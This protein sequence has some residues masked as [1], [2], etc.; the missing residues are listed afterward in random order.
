MS[1]GTQGIT[2]VASELMVFQTLGLTALFGDLLKHLEVLVHQL[3][4]VGGPGVA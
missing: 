4:Q 2:I 1:V 3:P